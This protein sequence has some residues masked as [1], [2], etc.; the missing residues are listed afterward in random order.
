MRKKGKITSLFL[1]LIFVLLCFSGCAQMNIINRRALVQ[2]IGLDWEDGKYVA[3]LEYFTPKG[4][5][6]QQI[7][8]KTANSD[9]VKGEGVTIASAIDNATFPEGRIPFYAQSSVMVVGRE[10]AEMSMDKVVDFVNFD[11]EFQV[12]TELFIADGKASEIICGDVDMGVLPGETIERVHQMYTTKG[13]MFN[14]EFYHFLNYYYNPYLA[15][16]VP[17]ISACDKNEGEKKK[18]S[19]SSEEETEPNKS[20]EY[21]GTM[22]VKGEKATGEL[23]LNQTR[24]ALFLC[25]SV[26][27]TS[28]N[29][30]LPDGELLS[31]NIISSETIIKPVYNGS[32]DILFDVQINNIIN[33]REYH[34]RSSQFENEE[35]IKRICDAVSKVIRQECQSAWNVLMKEQQADILGYGNRLRSAYP[36]LTDWLEKNLEDHLP[37]VKFELTINNRFE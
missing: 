23:N 22:I 24:G 3:T 29:T 33:L 7:D 30:V 32:D 37:Q 34:P 17:L 2:V 13:I 8:L 25:N 4:G 31:V 6:D 27:G 5:G 1:A 35:E 12:T 28:V 20:L 9:I 26:D 15:A 18:E 11:I 21:L 36:H 19:S 10:L 16:G 14:V